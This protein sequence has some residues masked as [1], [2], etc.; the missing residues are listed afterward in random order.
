MFLESNEIDKK[1]NEYNNATIDMF[2]YLSQCNILTRA[3]SCRA[4]KEP[5]FK[6]K[7]ESYLPLV[8]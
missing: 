8:C 2:C 4:R 1:M 5:W 3:K 6:T 7:K